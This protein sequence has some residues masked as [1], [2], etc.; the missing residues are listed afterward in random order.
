MM[1][2]HDRHF[3]VAQTGSVSVDA[4]GPSNELFELDVRQAVT[5]YQVG[6]MVTA[7]LDLEATLEAI[8]DATHQ[9]TGAN[10]TALALIEVDGSLVIRVGRGAGRS[11]IEH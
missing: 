9:L 4:A 3:S 1:P 10:T 11:A 6:K 2:D 5:L 8:T 7:S